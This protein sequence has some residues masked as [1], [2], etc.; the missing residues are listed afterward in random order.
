MEEQIKKPNLIEMA[1][2]RRHLALVEKLA[3]GKSSTPSLS[4]SEIRELE[5]FEGDPN[6]PGIV[7]SREKVAKV[8][9]VAWRT[10]ERWVKDGMPMTPDKKY[11]LLDIRSWR[12]LR[13]KR[14]K[15]PVKSEDELNKWKIEKIKLEVQ[16]RQGKL[17]SIETVENELIRLFI[18]VKRKMLNI[19]PTG[20]AIL[21]ARLGCDAR[22]AEVILD[23]KIKDAIKPLSTNTVLGSIKTKKNA[24]TN[25]K[26]E[27]LD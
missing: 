7:D 2:K 15:T 24:R 16:E 17:I 8:F 1:K 19:A 27:D 22:Q 20:A 4:K 5:N 21:S 11:N 10:V 9:G 3:K 12:E 23:A 26:P 18:E 14:K 13:L 6:T 25:S